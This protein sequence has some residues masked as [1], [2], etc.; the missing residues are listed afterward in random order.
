MAQSGAVVPLGGHDDQT[1]DAK[2]AVNWDST[3]E[4]QLAWMQ[5]RT[6]S[7]Y[8]NVKPETFRGLFRTD[9]NL[10]AMTEFLAT[11]DVRCLLFVGPKVKAT[12]AWPKGLKGESRVVYFLKLSTTPLQQQQLLQVSERRCQLSCHMQACDTFV[13]PSFVI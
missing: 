1:M 10:R 3:G 13:F 4:E 5:Q 8:K 6:L 12:L 2:D 7:A 9:E 11:P